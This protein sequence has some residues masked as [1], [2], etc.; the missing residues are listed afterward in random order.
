[1]GCSYPKG[2]SDSFA[3]S[4]KQDGIQM[5]G[6]S[7]G[8]ALWLTS[9]IRYPLCRRGK[10]TWAFTD[11]VESKVILPKE[12]HTVLE[13]SDLSQYS[14]MR[15]VSPVNSLYSPGRPFPLRPQ[16]PLAGPKPPSTGPK[17]PPRGLQE[18]SKRPPRCLNVAS[19]RPPRRLPGDPKK[20]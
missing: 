7:V 14:W 15:C 19:K 6:T 8:T 11:G 5:V 4:R 10:K 12:Y 2:G 20:L 3:T 18:T 16:R 1:M 17:R 13:P 9:Q